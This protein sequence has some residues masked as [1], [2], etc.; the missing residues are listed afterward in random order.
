MYEIYILP[1]R[2]VICQFINKGCDLSNYRSNAM[3]VLTDA[4]EGVHKIHISET[5]YCGKNLL[6]ARRIV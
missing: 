5:A 1:R 2:I 6:S 3:P 4:V